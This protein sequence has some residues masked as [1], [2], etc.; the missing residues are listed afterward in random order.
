MQLNTLPLGSAT[1]ALQ[2]AAQP[3]NGATFSDTLTDFGNNDVLD[4]LG[5][6]YNP[7]SSFATFNSL[8][9]TLAVIGDGT[10][11]SFILSDPGSAAYFTRD[12]GH[13]GTSV[14]TSPAC[15]CPGTLILTDNGNVPVETLAIGDTAITA[16]GQHRAL[17]WIGRRSYAGRFLA[18]NSAVQPIRFRAGSLGD[19]LPRRD[20]LVSP[21][22][23]MF[24]EGVLVP[25]E[26]LVNGVTIV[27]ERDLERV[28]YFH[29]ELDSHD[30]LLAEG[31]PSESFVDD[32][33]RGMFQNAHE[34]AALF[35]DYRRVPALYCA[36]RIDDG[37]TL[38]RIKRA[39][40]LRA[41]LTVA[42]HREPLRGHVDGW[43]GAT[44]RGWAQDPDKPEAPIC[45]EVLVDGVPGPRTLANLFRAD[46]R[47]AGLG[48]GCHA[49]RVELPASAVGRAVEVSRVL[50]G[51][52]LGAIASTASR[53]TAA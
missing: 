44:L 46:L 45:L 38:E 32:D 37:E 14:S 17:Q 35:P 13:G 2:G 41:G 26:C 15:Y 43:E 33:S 53:H 5:L 12:D 10:T 1:L 29:I 23:A 47:A 21:K 40:D 39:I 4:L 3:A 34:H 42:G 48:S 30:V 6:A 36:P 31:A 11:E 18:F 22:H 25:A 24:L 27:Q 9:D 52:V 51:A 19:E 50:D 8:S 16:S 49:F 20:L 28:D 7:L